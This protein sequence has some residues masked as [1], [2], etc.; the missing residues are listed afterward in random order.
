MSDVSK[1]LLTTADKKVEQKVVG[2]AGTPT[3]GD[4][5]KKATG[6]TLAVTTG[7]EDKNT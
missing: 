6:E 4:L 5:K 1:T 2:L 7:V 3:Y